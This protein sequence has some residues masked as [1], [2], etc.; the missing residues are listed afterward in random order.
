MLSCCPESHYFFWQ[1]AHSV[2]PW[3]TLFFTATTFL[4][5]IQVF[6]AILS[7]IN[8]AYQSVLEKS[9]VSN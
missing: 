8:A 2:G 1:V 9:S 7:V 4:G 6:S 3:C 5:G